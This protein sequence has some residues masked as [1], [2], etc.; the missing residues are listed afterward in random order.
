MKCF[1]EC[2]G[3]QELTELEKKGYL[4]N[5]QAYK[6]Y[7]TNSADA[8]YSVDEGGEAEVRSRVLLFIWIWLSFASTCRFEL[9]HQSMISLTTIT[10]DFQL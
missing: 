2:A 7:V 10:A 6:Q 8:A 5:I 4:N 1:L 3:E 9:S